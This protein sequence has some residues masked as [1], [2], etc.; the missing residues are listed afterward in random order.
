M[1]TINDFGAY[2]YIYIDSLRNY[3]VAKNPVFIANMRCVAIKKK[4]LIL[5]N[6][7]ITIHQLCNILNEVDFDDKPSDLKL[8]VKQKFQSELFS[9]IR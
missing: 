8:Q 6:K 1:D 9:L 2:E 7:V 4:D 3:R 5:N